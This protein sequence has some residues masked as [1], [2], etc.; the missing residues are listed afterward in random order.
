MSDPTRKDVFDE[1]RHVGRPNIG[2][3]EMFINYVNQIF[4]RQWLTNNGPLVQKLEQQ[5][6]DYLNVK[7]CVAMCNG[8]V[9][10]EILIRALELRGEV[11][12]P[13]YT[14]IA[15]AHAFHWLGLTPVFAEVDPLT[16][17]ITAKTAR[18]KITS[19]TTAILGVHLWGRPAPVDELQDLA[20][21]FNIELI[22]DAA[23]AFGCSRKGKMIGGFGR[24]EILSFHATKFFNTFEGGAIVTND[25]GLAEKSRLMRNFG[26]A[27]FDNVVCGGINGKMTEISAA[28]GLVN[29]DSIEGTVAINRNNYEVYREQLSLIPGLSIIDYD[30]CERNNY[31]YVVAEVSNSCSASRDKI[32]SCLHEHNVLARKYFW[33]GCHAMLPYRESDPEARGGLADSIALSERLFVLPTGRATSQDDVRQICRIIRRAVTGDS[34]LPTI[35]NSLKAG[36]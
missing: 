25:D 30:P 31:Q 26:F 2:S 32:V 14:F 13:S 21:E 17:N 23:H 1:T 24:A 5:V 4:D 34:P 6:C 11:I 19:R 8:T 27:G 3:R 12:V 16:H 18:A 33:P 7:H 36:T 9:A 28:M 35:Q 20:D 10:L 15:S 29:F 22:F